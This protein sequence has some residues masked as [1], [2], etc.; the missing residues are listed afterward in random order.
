GGGYSGYSGSYLRNSVIIDNRS[1][2]GN[3][4]G[5]Y[6]SWNMYVSNCVIV[7]NT[8]S[9]E[10]GGVFYSSS[11]KTI[12]TIAYCQ[13]RNNTCNSGAGGGGLS[14]Y[15]TTYLCNNLI[16]NNTNNAP[17]GNGGGAVINNITGLNTNVPPY[18]MVNCTIANNYSTNEGGGLATLGASNLVVN[19]IM[20]NNSSSAGDYPDVYNADVTNTNNFYYSCANVPLAPLPPSQANITNDPSFVNALAGNWRL[21]SRSPCVN[22][23]SNQSWMTGAVDL[24]G[25]MRIRYGTVDMGAYEKLYDGS[26]FRIR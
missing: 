25:R 1:T 19:C 6:A 10:G 22:A 7:G 17:S 9:G 5:I 12:H 18:G 13:I 11:D 8:C 23:G 14:I 26:V 20:A 21:I 16:C 3:G 24:D 15:N 2:N 4:G